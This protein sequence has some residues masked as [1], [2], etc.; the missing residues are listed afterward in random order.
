[1]RISSIFAAR[2]G[3]VIRL[4]IAKLA[5]PRARRLIMVVTGFSPEF[6]ERREQKISPVGKGMRRKRIPC[7]ELHQQE[8]ETLRLPPLLDQF[9]HDAF[10]SADE[11]EIGAGVPG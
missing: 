7:P 11:C 10:R 5:M 3:R 6:P 8:A 4:G 9:H 2:A 1:M